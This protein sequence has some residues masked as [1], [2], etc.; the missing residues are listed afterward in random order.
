VAGVDVGAKSP[1][2]T[3]VTFGDSITDGVRATTDS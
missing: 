1:M 3:I 2:R